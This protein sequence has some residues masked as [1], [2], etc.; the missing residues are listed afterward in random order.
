MPAALCASLVVQTLT[1]NSVVQQLE[2]IKA[3]IRQKCHDHAD[4]AAWITDIDKK[5]DGVKRTFTEM[6]DKIADLEDA[7]SQFK[8]TC[9]QIQFDQDL[10]VDEWINEDGCY[11]SVS[12][13][14][15]DDS[16]SEDEE[17]EYEDE[18]EEGVVDEGKKS[19]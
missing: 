7:R 19:D 16:D 15:H 2:D 6:E 12:S 1:M 14:E 8:K 3:N 9:K 4:F 10:A 5:I 13:L 17:G 18:D 11:F